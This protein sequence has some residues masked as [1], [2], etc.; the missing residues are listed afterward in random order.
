MFWTIDYTPLGL[1]WAGDKLVV[2]VREHRVT[3]SDGYAENPADLHTEVTK[4][5]TVDCSLGESLVCR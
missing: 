2:R 1:A 3:D 5:L 4:T